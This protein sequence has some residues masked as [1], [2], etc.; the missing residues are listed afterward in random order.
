MPNYHLGDVNFD[1]I[2][3]TRRAKQELTELDAIVDRI[4]SKASSI[5]FGGRGGVGIPGQ[6]NSQGQ[7]TSGTSVVPSQSMHGSSPI[8]G[9]GGFGA[10]A[11][12]IAGDLVGA[13]VLANSYLKMGG[14]QGNANAGGMSVFQRNQVSKVMFGDGP[15]E[16]G[17][18][19]TFMG[20]YGPGST[21]YESYIDEMFKRQGQNVREY[22]DKKR[23]IEDL[24][25][26]KK[27]RST[28]D[29]IDAGA[30]GGGGA[31]TSEG[32]GEGAEDKGSAK[33]THQT[34]AKAVKGLAAT[35]VVKYIGNMFE[36]SHAS[37]MEMI[38]AGQ[39][40]LKQQLGAVH[41]T[42][43]MIGSIPLIGSTLNQFAG[44]MGLYNREEK[45]TNLMRFRDAQIALHGMTG[46]AQGSLIS[47]E[48]GR[49]PLT[50]LGGSLSVNQASLVAGEAE[51]TKNRALAMNS[52]PAFESL[53]RDA[54]AIKKFTGVDVNTLSD[55]EKRLSGDTLNRLNKMAKDIAGKPYDDQSTALS[56]KTQVDNQAARRMY[57]L[58]NKYSAAENAGKR[59]TAALRP[60]AGFASSTANS[61]IARMQAES[62]EISE[63]RV[64][65]GIEQKDID[66][67]KIMRSLHGESS[68][69]DLQLAKT[70][71]L[72]N[73]YRGRPTEIGGMQSVE[74][75][76]DIGPETNEQALKELTI[77]INNLRAELKKP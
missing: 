24:I 1:V 53:T 17:T 18:I 47:S 73:V 35:L 41:R 59:L 12:G 39:D 15:G 23:T 68:I 8:P 44:G 19:G 7:P 3:E 38:D 40:P 55:D 16:K 30:G 75:M 63:M 56:N 31:G 32:A 70:G 46:A 27:I 61:A 74:A 62:T 58:G 13:T 14:I 42:Q 43:D 67:A 9:G 65:D 54:E 71:V 33:W 50:T 45:I 64:G 36:S 4:R 5:G 77:A 29:Q 2:F 26:K 48:A 66:R 60:Q 21:A 20:Q 51:I 69:A 34:I 49:F 72:Q 22:K 25:S 52:L 6:A 28:G 37:S 10:F 76:R 11:G 57:D